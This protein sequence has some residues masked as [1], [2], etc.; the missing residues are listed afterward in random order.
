MQELLVAAVAQRHVAVQ[1]YTMT[2]VLGMFFATRYVSAVYMGVLTVL[3]CRLWLLEVVCM[4][5]LCTVE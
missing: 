4:H 2:G 5:V 3:W 1:K